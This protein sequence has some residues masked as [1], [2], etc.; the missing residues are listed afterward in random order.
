MIT[1]LDGYVDEPSCLGVPPYISPIVR[2]IYGAVKDAG[3]ESNYITIDEYRNNS[4]KLKHLYDSKILIIIAG[5]VVP[6]RYIR[7]LPISFNEIIRI[8]QDFNG[9]KILG[10]AS[11]IYGFGREKKVKK[12]D[13]KN[14]EDHFDFISYKDTDA[15]IFDHLSGN[16]FSNRK[17]TEKEW[18]R[19][20]KKG[21]DI[22]KHHPDFPQPLIAEI[23]FSRGCVRYLSGGCSFC[24]EPKFGEPIF[25]ESKDIIEEIKILNNFGVTNFRLG[26]GSCIF[27]YHANGIGENEAPIP[28]IIEIKKLLN[29]IRNNAPKLR[30]L[31]LDNANPAIIAENLKESERVIKL[32]IEHCTSGNALSFGLESAD[33]EVIKK[34]NL[35]STPEQVLKAI[36]LVNKYGKNIGENG[37]PRLLPGLNIIHGLNGESK[38]TFEINFEFLKSIMEKDL[39]LRRI[40]IRQVLDTKKQELNLNKYN[41]DFIKFK[42]KVREE[43]DRELLKKIVPY[44]TLLKDVFIEGNF[45]NITYARQIGTYPLLVGIPYKLKKTGFTDIIVTDHGFRSI[46]GIEQPFCINT[47]SR[48]ALEALPMVGKKRAIQILAKRPFINEVDF[49]NCLDDEKVGLELL[50][51]V[52]LK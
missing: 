13:L 1:I 3:F 16:N 33:P 25:K 5:V 12:S 19:W 10:G 35:N 15:F 28:N 34:N 6:G 31:H 2:Y 43:I 23:E 36:E 38:K 20:S 37:M 18:I 46:T 8:S 21:A 47:A 41:K 51:F 22:V 52:N 14:L 11:S 40:N 4:Q 29:G 17:R 48:K 26:G 30:V 44:K 49:I 27:S 39:L 50:N 32:I 42:K 45:N 9:I 7:A 24:M